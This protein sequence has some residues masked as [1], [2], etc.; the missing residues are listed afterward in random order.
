MK[1]LF[2]SI[3]VCICTALCSAVVAGHAAEVPAKAESASATQAKPGNSASLE[4]KLLG[5]WYGPCCGGDYTFNAD[6]TYVVQN[7]TPGGNT[8]TGTWS[9]RW[10]ALPPTLILLC[11]TSDFTKNDSD[12]TE[13]EYLGK[14]V[15]IKLVEL[16]EKNFSYRTPDGKRDWR[17][18]RDPAEGG[19]TKEVK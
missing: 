6:G 10:D 9:I 7:F 2:R 17:F 1:T 11:K 14:P 18:S 12:R 15:E 4:K 19:S 8:L 13:Y 5:T 16:N 3:Q